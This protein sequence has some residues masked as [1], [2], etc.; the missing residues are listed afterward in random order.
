M[1]AMRERRLQEKDAGQSNVKESLKF[2]TINVDQALTTFQIVVKRIQS[3]EKS[4]QLNDMAMGVTL[5]EDEPEQL[6]ERA[7][8][9][10]MD[11]IQDLTKTVLENSSFEIWKV[12]FTSVTR[13]CDET[14][15]QVPL[16]RNVTFLHVIITVTPLV[17]TAWKD[18]K[19]LIDHTH[20]GR[21][22]VRSRVNFITGVRGRMVFE[23]QTF[24]LNAG[25]VMVVQAPLAIKLKTFND[26]R[27]W[28]IVMTNDGNPVSLQT[29]VHNDVTFRSFT[30]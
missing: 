6:F 23:R 11:V 16:Q 22:D 10:I 24:V 30:E 5:S 13:L 14:F 2:F 18:S 20:Y 7:E 29:V 4:R 26:T 17:V 12:A 3:D 9:E 28:K 21:S 19:V 15:L 25:E 27:Y 8:D 1:R